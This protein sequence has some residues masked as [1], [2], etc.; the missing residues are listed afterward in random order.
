LKK[1][2]LDVLHLLKNL[3]FIFIIKSLTLLGKLHVH[4]NCPKTVPANPGL[5]YERHAR[6]GAGA[7]CSGFIPYSRRCISTGDFTGVLAR[8]APS[9]LF[10]IF[11]K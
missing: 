8:V 6:A 2:R 3:A 1:V 10:G 5:K 11:Q 9:V 7:V 4:V